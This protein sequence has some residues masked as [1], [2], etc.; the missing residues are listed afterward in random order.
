[1]PL[2]GPH[3]SYPRTWSRS[4]SNL[5]SE[6]DADSISA[7]LARQWPPSE[8]RVHIQVVGGLTGGGISVRVWNSSGIK[9]SEIVYPA[10]HAGCEDPIAVA[11]AEE[12][13]CIVNRLLIEGKLPKNCQ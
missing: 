1:M 13:Q 9:E 6:V 11:V 12:I 10:D 3:S 5:G 7:N 8:Y 2:D 4:A